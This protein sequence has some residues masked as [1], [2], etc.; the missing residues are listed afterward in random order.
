M[1]SDPDALESGQDLTD[2]E[3]LQLKRYIETRI[4]EGRAFQTNTE[5]A[6]HSGLGESTI[7]KMRGGGSIS[8]RTFNKLAKAFGFRPSELKRELEKLE[9]DIEIHHDI[10]DE[11]RAAMADLPTEDQEEILEF[12]RLKAERRRRNKS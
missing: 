12:I 11:I 10:N 2:A 6:E 3:V 1:S 8:N 9:Q 7:R 5:L 4:G